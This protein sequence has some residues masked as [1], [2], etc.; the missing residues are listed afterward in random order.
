MDTFGLVAMATWVMQQMQT[1]SYRRL[2][3]IGRNLNIPPYTFLL[4]DG[5]YPSIYPLLTPFRRIR[6][7]NNALQARANRHHRR[8]RVRVEHRIGDVRIYRSVPGRDGRFRHRRY[9]SPLVTGVVIALTNRRRHLIA[10]M[11]RMLID[12]L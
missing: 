2:P 1:H 11:R 9:L 3:Q 7:H 4:A 10:R 6:G 12:S 8:I 5:G